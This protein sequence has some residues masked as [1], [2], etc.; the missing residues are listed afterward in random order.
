[1][2]D[3][4]RSKT[5]SLLRK[6]TRCRMCQEKTLAQ[7]LDLGSHVP[8]DQFRKKEE[9]DLPQLSYP[10]RVMLCTNCGLSQLSHVVDPRILYQFDYPYESGTTKSGKV[11]WDEFAKAVTTRLKLKP[12]SLIVDMGSN[13]GT[14]LTSFQGEGMKIVGIDPAPNIVV[15]ANTRGIKTYCAFF[16]RTIAE[17]VRN[18]HGAASVIVGTNV[19]AHI[20]DLHEV[21]KAAKQLLSTDGVF[22]FES[23]HFEHLVDH[24]EYDTVYH[25][26][27]SY[28]S[29]APVVA[30]VKQFGMEVFAVEETGIHG[31]SFRVYIGKKGRRE[32]DK[33]V[34]IILQREK[35]KKLHD[36]KT[37]K[38]FAKRVE[39]NRR[40]L[41]ELIE[42]LLH[43]GKKIALL[44]T[45]A[46]G[47]TLINYNGLTLRHTP[48]ATEKTNLKIGRY[49]PGAHIPILPDS[50]LLTE[51][52]DYALLLAWN[53]A[54]EIIKNNEAFTK[55]GG[56]FIIPI[57]KPVIR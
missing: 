16:D 23:P 10:L 37:M 30:F 21:L 7:Y 14:L 13:D 39:K 6:V 5:E 45:P 29:L 33:S 40:D 31:G 51:D 15:L 28:L 54:T 38:D 9:L 22:I 46:K 35:K 47:M 52:A 43:Q 34:A 36:L 17:K 8:A 49:T 27:L 41:M 18:V 11:H 55:K 42:K 20:D 50:A 4:Q 25:E 53:F 48:F 12:K 57:P 32:I 19:F 1:M 3:L 2:K 56:K 44:S 26:H 24:L